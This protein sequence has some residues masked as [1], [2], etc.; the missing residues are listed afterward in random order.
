MNATSQA[1]SGKSI[2][3]TNDSATLIGIYISPDR[4][5][6]S[7]QGSH[8]VLP[9]GNHFQGLGSY[10]FMYEETNNGKLA[11]YARF[12]ILPLQSYRAF[13]FEWTAQPPITEMAMFGYSQHCNGTAAYYAS[14]NGATQVA[15]WTFFGSTSQSGTFVKAASASKGGAFETFAPGAFKPFAYA[16]AYDST[17]KELGRTSVVK[18]FVPNVALA[19]TCNTMSCPQGTNY[20]STSLQTVCATNS[21]ASPA[22]LVKRALLPLSASS[23]LRK[24]HATKSVTRRPRPVE[25]SSIAVHNKRVVTKTRT[26]HATKTSVAHEPQTTTSGLHRPQ[27]SSVVAIHKRVVT[28]TR[29]K[30][31][32]KTS[33][34]H[35]PLTSSSALHKPQSISSVA[36][37]RKRAVTKTRTGHHVTK[38]SVV[39]QPQTTSLPGHRV[40][41]PSVTKTKTR[42]G[43]KATTTVARGM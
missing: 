23:S 32:T 10:P 25:T 34:A 35:K 42:K 41:K 22:K 29:T 26:K 39:H 18:T 40:K 28:K 2:S 15:T 33:A 21:S 11:F 7:S 36:P 8:Q 27:T 37:N 19:P 38:S 6:D 16:V 31:A 3:I 12:G 30:H 9:N 4:Q 24:H 1:S 14:W 43:P 17:G 5:L 13:R 20:T